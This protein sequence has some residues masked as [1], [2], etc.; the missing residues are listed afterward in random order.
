MNCEYYKEAIDDSQFITCKMCHSAVHLLCTDSDASDHLMQAV[1]LW[2]IVN[3]LPPLALDHTIFPHCTKKSPKTTAK[4]L[5]SLG[6]LAHTV[7]ER[8]FLA[9][10]VGHLALV[11]LPWEED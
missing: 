5:N 6:D 9:Y 1:K 3:S 10:H 4:L 2:L 7:D 11:S 8:F